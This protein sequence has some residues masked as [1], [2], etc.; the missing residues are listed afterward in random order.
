MS[1]WDLSFKY[2]KLE[3]PT[4]CLIFLGMEV[5]TESLQL[6]LPSNELS[7]LNFELSQCFYCYLI[8][9]WEIA[10]YIV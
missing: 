7:R 4:S 8:S 3:G 10:T 2:S 6:R 1:P 9:K 5:D